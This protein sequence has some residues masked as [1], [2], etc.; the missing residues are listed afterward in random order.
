MIKNPFTDQPVICIKRIREWT[1][2][3]RLFYA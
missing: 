3:G 2:S 1:R